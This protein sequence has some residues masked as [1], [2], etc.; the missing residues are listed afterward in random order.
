MV[1]SVSL[2]VE[3]IVIQV[4]FVYPSFRSLVIVFVFAILC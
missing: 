1:V 3:H 4:S 2:A